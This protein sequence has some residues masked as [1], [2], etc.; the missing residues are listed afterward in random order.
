MEYFNG[1]PSDKHHGGL[2]ESFDIEPI[3]EA[4]GHASEIPGNFTER[5]LIKA[6]EAG[7]WNIKLDDQNGNIRRIQLGLGYEVEQGRDPDRRK[8]I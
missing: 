8:E 3:I 2:H 7:S 1:R 5:D 6:M 4:L